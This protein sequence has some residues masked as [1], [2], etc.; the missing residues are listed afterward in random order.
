ML[1]GKRVVSRKRTDHF[2]W[3]FV[4]EDPSFLAGPD[5]LAEELIKD[6]PGESC[7][8]FLPLTGAIFMSVLAVAH[9]W[10][11]KALLQASLPG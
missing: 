5:E 11:F 4:P 2:S 10:I 3:W 1:P 6:I 8:M 9:M 7:C